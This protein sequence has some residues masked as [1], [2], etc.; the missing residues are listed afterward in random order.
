MRE[1]LEVL[2]KIKNKRTRIRNTFK[3][4]INNL[5][6]FFS[7]V[8][9]TDIPYIR[10]G[11]FTCEGGDFP[12]YVFYNT[13]IGKICCDVSH[14]SNQELNVDELSINEIKELLKSIPTVFREEIERFKK[15]LKKDELYAEIADDLY[16]D[17]L[18]FVK[19]IVH[20]SKLIE[21]Q[22]K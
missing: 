6:S 15:I 14:Q 5:E 9:P 11:E 8:V 1:F 21:A 20:I 18:L 12:L 10:L 13:K 19:L 17:E 16:K 22:K 4:F 3:Q 2:E 7:T